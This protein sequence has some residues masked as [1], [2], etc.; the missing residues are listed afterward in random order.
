MMCTWVNEKRTLKITK[1]FVLG[2]NIQ[3]CAHSGFLIRLETLI[4]ITGFIYWYMYLQNSNIKICMALAS[5][6]C[7]LIHTAETCIHGLLQLIYK[8]INFD[9]LRLL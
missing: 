1:L 7:K 4:R 8:C 3:F 9:C 2:Y 5:L 6:Q